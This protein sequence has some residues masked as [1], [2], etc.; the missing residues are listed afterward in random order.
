MLDRVPLLQSFEHREIEYLA[1][2]CSAYKV[3]KGV[4]IFKEGEQGNY[5]CLL[6]DGY[7]VLMKGGKQLATV[8]EG[9]IMGEM[10]ML[11]EL[12]YSATAISAVDAKFILINRKQLER[13]EQQYPQVA[14]K[15]LRA[16]GKLIS[17]RLRETTN[18]LF[19]HL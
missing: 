12:P 1:E 9:R 11:D 16:L 19:A 10:S 4:Q 17:I 6:T 18:L 7:V 15:L 8:R 3:A 2:H 14:I 13:L 5:M